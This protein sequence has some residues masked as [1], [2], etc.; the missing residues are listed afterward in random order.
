MGRLVG[1]LV[2]VIVL[3]IAGALIIGTF[4]KTVAKQQQVQ[5]QVLDEIK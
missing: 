1:M 3:L 4:E 2:V 5:S